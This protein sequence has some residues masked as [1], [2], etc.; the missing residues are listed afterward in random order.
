MLFILVII[1]ATLNTIFQMHFGKLDPVL[2]DAIF[3]IL[4]YLQMCQII[5]SLGFFNYSKSDIS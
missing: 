3:K 4:L 1:K 2:K 5:Y